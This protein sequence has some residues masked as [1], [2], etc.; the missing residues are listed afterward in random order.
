MNGYEFVALGFHLLSFFVG[1][2]VSSYSGSLDDVEVL[3]LPGVLGVL[4]VEC[5]VVGGPEMPMQ[6]LQLG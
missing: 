3:V 2:L 4:L 6:F 5:V 1:V